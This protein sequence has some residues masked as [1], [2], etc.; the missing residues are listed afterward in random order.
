V[1]EVATHADF[2]LSPSPWR[3][4]NIVGLLSGVRV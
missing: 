1:L 3:G 2:A 4:D